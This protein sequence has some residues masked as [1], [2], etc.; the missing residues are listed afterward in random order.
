MAE[1]SA[2]PDQE[3]RELRMLGKGQYNSEKRKEVGGLMERK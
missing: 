1:A 3:R 2:P